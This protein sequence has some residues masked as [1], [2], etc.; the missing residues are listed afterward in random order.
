PDLMRALTA[1]GRERGATLFMTL[2]AAFKVLLYRYSGQDDIVVGTPVAGR[3]RAELENLI[4]CFIN[5]LPLRTDLSDAPD[6]RTLLARI[7][8]ATLEAFAHQAVPFEKLVESLAPARDPSR[9]PLFQVLFTLQNLP[10]PTAE[11][12][13]LRLE[14]IALESEHAQYDLSL[15]LNETPDGWQGELEYNADLFL[16]ATAQRLARH[17][18]HLLQAIAADPGCA[19]DR[20][21]LLDEG[22]RRRM[23]ELGKGPAFP[24]HSDSASPLPGGERSEGLEAGTLGRLESSPIALHRL[25]EAQAQRTP[26][27]V[28]V[29]D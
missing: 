13:G 19:V 29:T 18:L 9:S 20:L 28:A 21:P 16:P 5:L 11:F 22:E 2:L 6:F 25:F 4:G 14:P 26:N 12:G 24:S 3:N 10:A 8:H 27:A 17:W 15:T 7:R 23:L 1:L